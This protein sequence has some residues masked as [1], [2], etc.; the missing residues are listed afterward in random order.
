MG[1]GNLHWHICRQLWLFPSPSSPGCAGLRATPNT[2]YPC[3]TL[4][5]PF[6]FQGSSAHL[7]PTQRAVPPLCFYPHIRH[8][9]YLGH[10]QTSLL[11]FTT[12]VPYNSAFSLSPGHVPPTSVTAGPNAALPM[13]FSLCQ[14]A[15]LSHHCQTTSSF[16]S[17]CAKCYTHCELLGEPIGGKLA[18]D[19]GCLRESTKVAVWEDREQWD[20]GGPTPHVSLLLCQHNSLKAHLLLLFVSLHSVC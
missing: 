6:P 15:I 19:K 20:A 17:C 10:H 7:P 1:R 9:S 16:R 3:Q 4:L 18:H 11:Q 13:P 8:H 2:Y 12:A 5:L 14:S